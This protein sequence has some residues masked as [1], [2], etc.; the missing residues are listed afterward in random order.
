MREFDDTKEGLTKALKVPP[1]STLNLPDV[2]V[3]MRDGVLQAVEEGRELWV[4]VC[5]A[6]MQGKEVAVERAV[7]QA[8]G[9]S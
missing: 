9:E 5:D 2:C 4:E 6:V 1:P 8:L 7:Q 3:S